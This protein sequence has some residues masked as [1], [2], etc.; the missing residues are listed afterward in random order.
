MQVVPLCVTVKHNTEE[1]P[2]KKRRDRRVAYCKCSTPLFVCPFLYTFSIISYTYHMTAFT[3]KQ[4]SFEG[5]LEALLALVEKRRMH[6][7]DVALAAVAD[8]FL[9]YAKSHTDFPLAESAQFAFIAAT[10]LLIK[11]RSLLPALALTEEEEASAEELERRLRMLNRFRELS[12]A[13]SERFGKRVLFFPA[14][15]TLAP[16]FAPPPALSLSALYSALREVLASLPKAE[17]L[18]K[19][20]VQKVISLEEVIVNLS[21]RVQSAIQ[22]S[23][24]EFTRAHKGEKAA[25]IVSFLALLELV[26]RGIV[27]ARQDGQGGEIVMQTERVDIPRY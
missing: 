19:V 23:F 10:L 26:R 12:H 8:D 6:I 1:L 7:N 27:A 22:M 16:T 4:E 3:V 5:P 25:I 18:P 14:E 11:S 9:A 20:I 2:E 15:R 24:R 17:T 13:V 21:R